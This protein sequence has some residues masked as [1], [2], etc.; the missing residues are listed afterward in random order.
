SCGEA[1][2]KT[3]E[4]I[5]ALEQIG[6]TMIVQVY[7]DGFD[8]L[9]LQEKVTAYYLYRAAIAGRDITYDQ[10]HKYAL[11]IRKILDGIAAHPAGIVPDAYNKILDYTKLFWINNGMYNNRTREKF[12]P[13]V[14][15]DTFVEA[16][17]T[18]QESGAD[19]GL[20]PGENIEEKLEA[21]RRIIFDAGFEPLLA[22]K[23]PRPEEDV[24][25]TSANNLYEGVTA[26]EARAFQ[27]VAKN[28]LNSKLIKQGGQLIEL[29]YR[30]GG[31]GVQPGMYATE[32]SNIIEEF[33]TGMPFTTEA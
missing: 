21:L 26:D 8:D 19:M 29:V 20:K 18:A 5:Y 11:E 4:R 3:G 16:A 25:Q 10:H 30:A 28:P 23:S 6:T 33:E 12:V 27:D 9:T 2:Q 24:L 13:E 22:N 14:E 1:P 15:F 32:L 7:T 17:R 31:G